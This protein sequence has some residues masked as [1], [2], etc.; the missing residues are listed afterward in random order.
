MKVKNDQGRREPVPHNQK[1]LSQS[2]A[3]KQLLTAKTKGLDS[4][5]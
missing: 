1:W 2:V 5:H 3:V 4:I